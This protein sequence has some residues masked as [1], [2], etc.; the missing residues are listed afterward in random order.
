M[1]NSQVIPEHELLTFLRVQR[2]LN[3]LRK[4][5]PVKT[6]G[7]LNDELEKLSSL[8]V[9]E[10]PVN[11]RFGKVTFSIDG[12]AAGSLENPDVDLIMRKSTISSF[13]KGEKTVT[14]EAYRRGTEIPGAN[15]S[16]DD[17]DWALIQDIKRT[18]S[19]T[20]F[21]GRAVTVKLYK[22]AV[23]TD[24][25]HFDWHRDTTHSDQHH[26]TVLIALNTSWA[27]GD[28]I[29]RR[30]GVETR[31]DMKPNH[32]QDIKLE[33]GLSNVVLQAVAFYTDTEHKV[34]PVSGGVRI[35]LQYDIEVK[36]LP[37]GYVDGHEEDRDDDMDIDSEY[38]E[39]VLYNVKYVYSGRPKG[40][41]KVPVTADP[42]VIKTIISI[43]K[44]TLEG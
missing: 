41:A 18:V 10:F 31:T 4:G 23:Y 42:D 3:G 16:F 15:I 33:D 21:A 39:P 25:G 12:E 9:V 6:N 5:I 38:F 8:A 27:G 1:S 40:L 22:L 34:E 29:L 26:A 13:G 20:M 32:I 44:S 11:N 2:R 36:G 35:I 24:G 14:D 28:L 7:R 37:K 43:I 19:A 30:N 17:D